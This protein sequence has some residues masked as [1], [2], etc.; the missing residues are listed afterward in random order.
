[1]LKPAVVQKCFLCRDNKLP[2]IK[3]TK[4]EYLD[5]IEKGIGKAMK[6][7]EK[8]YRDNPGN[9]KSMIIYEILKRKTASGSPA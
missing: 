6:K 5:A 3:I 1:M 8:I 9:Q 7:K 4:G 2:F